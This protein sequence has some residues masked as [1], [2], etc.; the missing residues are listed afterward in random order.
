MS[1]GQYPLA[2]DV[3]GYCVSGTGKVA[4]CMDKQDEMKKVQ[5]AF[6]TLWNTI[7]ELCNTL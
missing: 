2:G 3:Y 4:T 7:Q 1:E 5:V 6:A